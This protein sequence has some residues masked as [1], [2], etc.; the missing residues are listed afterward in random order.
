[1][2]NFPLIFSIWSKPVYVTIYCIYLSFL[3]KG[4]TYYSR[5]FMTSA[6]SIHLKLCRVLMP[7]VHEASLH[8]THKPLHPNRQFLTW[9]GQGWE[10]A[11][12]GRCDWKGQNELHGIVGIFLGVWPSQARLVVLLDWLKVTRGELTGSRM[13]GL[14]LWT[15]KSDVDHISYWLLCVT[16]CQMYG[17]QCRAYG[18]VS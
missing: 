7:I 10:L 9:L 6:L 12:R 2:N 1:M 4:M 5:S 11:S 15:R 3:F 13:V 8:N 17:V 14:G 16:K 18:V